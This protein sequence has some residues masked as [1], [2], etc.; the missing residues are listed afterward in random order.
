MCCR[1][2]NTHVVNTLFVVSSF[3]GFGDLAAC[4]PETKEWFYICSFSKEGHGGI[5]LAELDHSTGE[6]RVIRLVTQIKNTSL[7]GDSSKSGIL[8]CDE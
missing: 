7:C 8:I 3:V 2:V 4:P 1:S 6:L 5:H